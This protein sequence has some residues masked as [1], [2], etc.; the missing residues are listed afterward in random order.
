MYHL[1]IYHKFDFNDSDQVQ[2]GYWFTGELA[3]YA[4][5]NEMAGYI[6]HE[7]HDEKVGTQLFGFKDKLPFWLSDVF[8]DFEENN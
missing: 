1:S 4:E 6:K 2:R 3:Q 7:N 8:I 5:D